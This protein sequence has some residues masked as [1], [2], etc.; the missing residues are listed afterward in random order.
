MNVH[1]QISQIENVPNVSYLPN[2]RMLKIILM[3]NNLHRV[4]SLSGSDRLFADQEF[5]FSITDSNSSLYIVLIDAQPDNRDIATV[6]LQ[7][8]LYKLNTKFRES[9]RMRPLIAGIPP[10]IITIEL[11]TYPSNIPFYNPSQLQP[12]NQ[13]LRQVPQMVHPQ[14][15]PMR[16]I[17]QYAAQQ[18][19]QPPLYNIQQQPFRPQ[20]GPEIYDAPYIPEERKVSPLIAHTRTPQMHAKMFAPPTIQESLARMNN[21][22][23]GSSSVYSVAEDYDEED[24][25]SSDDEFINAKVNFN[26]TDDELSQIV[27]KARHFST[28]KINPNINVNPF[29]HECQNKYQNCCPNPNQ[30]NTSNDLMKFTQNANKENTQINCMMVKPTVILATVNKG[31]GS[32]PFATPVNMEPPIAFETVPSDNS[33][34]HYQPTNISNYQNNGYANRG[35][36]TQYKFPFQPG[37]G[38]NQYSFQNH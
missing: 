24:Y 31:D 4:A 25:S 1:L 15:L 19:T 21:M 28:P 27:H 23:S 26:A 18:A 14:V 20:P 13:Q 33:I 30:Q 38:Q 3:P 17:P 9:Y 37:M 12:S 32:T 16:P 8:G 5:D 35:N 7:L 2:P 22:K 36:N 34:P 29:Q 6:C 11:K 10:P